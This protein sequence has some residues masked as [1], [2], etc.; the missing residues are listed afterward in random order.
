MTHSII[1]REALVLDGTGAS[2]FVA[3]VALDGDVIAEIGSVSGGGS[4]EIDCRG[5][6]LSPGFIDVHTHDDFALRTS[7]DMAFKTLQGVTTVVTGNCGTSAVPMPQWLEGLRE[8]PAA[9]NVA[10]L[11]GHGSVREKVIGRHVDRHATE[12]ESAQ[13]HSL[14]TEAMESGAIGMSTGL[15]Y[16]P[17]R[18]SPTEEIASLASIVA[19]AGG[20]YTS[21]MRNERNMLLESVQETIHIGR[22]T[23]VRVQVSHL[24]AIG[25]ENFGLASRAVEMIN[26]ARTEGLEVAADQYPYTRGSTA[27]EQLVTA[28]AFDGPSPFGFVQADDVLIASAP[29]HPE[30]EGTTLAQVAASLGLDGPTAARHLVDAEGT[31]CMIVYANQSE[32]NVELIMRQPYVMIGSDGIPAGSNPHP[33]LHHTFPR[34]LGEYCRE[35]GV[36][37]LAEAIHRMTGLA[38]DWFRLT[39]RGV[40]QTG[41][42]ADL[43]LFDP[44]S[45]RDTGTYENPTLSPQGF[46]GTWVNGARV[47]E[48]PFPTSARPGRVLSLT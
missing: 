26:S 16:A 3:D 23:G 24:K 29:L 38:A 30:W 36:I 43:V 11:V 42:F 22:V 41:S 4:E 40:V 10:A 45:V 20:I 33:R 6:A 37:G 27:L 39:G 12:Q 47:V 14:V 35:R 31:A 15:V 21:H 28:G 7:P 1:F 13:M 25:A 9:V 2:P 44:S 17:G 5:L 32:S 8:H 46:H 48:G 18:F 34:V 19:A